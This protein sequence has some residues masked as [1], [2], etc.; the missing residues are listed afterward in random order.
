[1]HTTGKKKKEKETPKKDLP[2]QTPIRTLT[3]TG[4]TYAMHVHMHMFAAAAVVIQVS[5]TTANN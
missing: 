5:G 3:S 1:M 2:I 4:P